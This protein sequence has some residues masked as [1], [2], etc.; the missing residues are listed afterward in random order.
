M[1]A[2]GRV[3]RKP[4]IGGIPVAQRVSRFSY[5]IRNIVDAAYAEEAR[6]RTVRYLNIGDPVAFGFQ[7]PPHLIAAVE[8]AIRDGANGYTPA[9]GIWEV[10]EA[11]ANSYSTAGAP[12]EPDRIILTSGT[13]EGIE[14]VL[15]VLVNPG[16]EL[17]GIYA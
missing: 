17:A 4:A 1:I 8:R 11:V 9:A 10:R 16:D 14:L 13:S 5:A 12:I 2:F 15:S 3:I 6:G 7:T